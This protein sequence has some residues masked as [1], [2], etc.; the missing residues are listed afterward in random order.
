[1][2]GKPYL[3]HSQ[4][5]LYT[6]CG[7]A[8]RRRY[9]EKDI[10]PPGV[11]ALRGTSVHK[12]AEANYDQKI[13]TRRDMKPDMLAEI[14]ASVFEKTVKYED[15]WLNPEE[16]SV[17][18]SKVLGEA[19]DMA[20]R[21]TMLFGKQ[22]APKYMPKHVELEHRI[23]LPRSSHDLLG[24]IDLITEDDVIQDLK[25][26]TKKTSPEQI[27]NDTQL[28]FYAL[29]FHNK[30][31]RAPKALVIDELVDAKEP[32]VNSVMTDRHQEDFEV[33]TNRINS[34][35]KG[36]KAGVFTPASSGGWWCSAKWCGFHATCSHVS[37]R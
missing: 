25:T 3:S 16:Q 27:H 10:I 12:G 1:M 11:A 15:V 14:T 31:G 23:E 37:H 17:G 22:V 26:R 6:K 24:R 13:H 35:V 4:I 32:T 20:T 21:L 33:L 19:K 18:K 29:A 36:I 30:F 28:T 5:S 7:E 9:V 8:Y 34:V 2:K